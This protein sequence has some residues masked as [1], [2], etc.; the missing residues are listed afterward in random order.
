MENSLGNERVLAVLPSEEDR[1]SLEAIFT[2][3]S[4]E[5]R[6]TRNFAEAQAA[7]R[8]SRFA[9]VITDARLSPGQGWKEILA[10]L[11]RMASPPPLVVADCLADERMW[12]EVLNLGAHDLLLKPFIAR[13]VLHVVGLACCSH[14]LPQRTAPV[15]KPAQSEPGMA[16]R[17]AHAAL[18]GENAG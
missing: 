17:V 7:L 15:R 18:S 4:W 14:K 6:F 13:E 5:I 2:R 10:E 3:S 9:L 16:S 11:D 1:D 8:S 12:A